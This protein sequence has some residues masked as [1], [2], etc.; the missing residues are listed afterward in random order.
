MSDISEISGT[1]EMADLHG[2]PDTG[3][4]MTMLEALAAALR[5]AMARDTSVIVLGE[6]I[7]DRHGSAVAVSQQ[8]LQEFGAGRVIDLPP[9]QAALAGMAV[10]AALMGLR[11]VVE[12][13]SADRLAGALEQI[14]HAASFYWRTGGDLAVPIVF[15]AP[16]GDTRSGP[17][18]AA[19]PEAWL[20]HI[21]GLRVVAPATPYDAKGLLAAA[22]RDNNPVV[23]LEHRYLYRRLS[24]ALPAEDFLVPLDAAE[25]RLPGDQVTIL[26]YGALVYA[27]LEAADTLAAD[28]ISAEV[29]DLR[30]LAPLD[31]A[32]IAASVARTNRALITHE[33]SLTAGL[34]AEIAAIVA[35]ECFS[36]LD[37]PVVRIAAPDTPV[38]LA[39]TL[40]DAHIPSAARIAEAARLLVTR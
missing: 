8:M 13:P 3:G 38:P 24:E 19:S 11:P 10:G 30:A 39:G 26:T 37:A 22:I 1:I 2:L 15:R 36:V 5:S 25:V 18:H 31:R 21:P 32:T 40:A 6:R 28:G 27:A 17:W 14:A 35:E 29:V 34:G 20:A 16:F 7:G 4:E 33:A 9:T 12:L 23:V